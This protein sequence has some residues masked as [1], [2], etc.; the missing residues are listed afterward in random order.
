M[1]I[2]CVLSAYHMNEKASKS[3]IH[4]LSV[5]SCIHSKTYKKQACTYVCLHVAVLNFQSVFAYVLLTQCFKAFVSFKD[6]AVFHVFSGAQLHK[7][8]RKYAQT[9]LGRP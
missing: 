3:A 7:G 9:V 4:V 6:T 2:E 5:R 8:F 1:R